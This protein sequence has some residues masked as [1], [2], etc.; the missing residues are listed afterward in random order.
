MAAAPL[1]AWVRRMVL[2]ANPTGLP[3]N[4][5]RTSIVSKPSVP[6]PSLVIAPAVLLPAAR[7]TGRTRD[8]GTFL[9]RF[10]PP[11]SCRIMAHL[12]PLSEV[13]LQEALKSSAAG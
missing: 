10:R 1:P 8:R 2:A 6:R 7:L 12:L 11:K 4:I 3:D 9:F 5:C 13:P